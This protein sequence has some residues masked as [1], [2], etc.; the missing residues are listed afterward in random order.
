MA[1]VITQIANER[2]L[3]LTV[4]EGGNDE[5]GTMSKAFNTMISVIHKAFIVVNNSAVNVAESAE[6]VA[7]RAAGNR[8]RAANE[9]VRAK[10]SVGIIGDMGSTAAKVNQ[11]SEGQKVAAEVSA[12]TVRNLLKSVGEVSEAAKT[13]NKEA[14]ETM[15]R[16]SEMGATGAQV[17][18][19]AR[20][21]GAMVAKVSTAVTSITSAVESMNK[22][23]AQATL[24]G[25]ASL[26]AA[27]E[28]RRSVASTVEGMQAI[29]ESSEQISDIIGVITEIAEQTNL[30]A[31]NAAIEAA[32]AGAHGKGFAVV[33]DEVGKLAQRSSEAAKEITQLIKDSSARVEDG[34][35][36]TDESQKSL[37]K[38][39]EGGR[40]NMQAIDEIEKTATVLATGTAQVQNLMKELNKLA[41][42]IAGMAGEQGTRRVAAEKALTLLLEESERITALVAEANKGATD[43]GQE[44]TGIVVRT[45]EMSKM[46]GEQAI[47]SKKV[48]ELSTASADAAAQ[49]VE[50][51]GVVVSITKGLQDLSQ[52]LTT[53]VKQFKI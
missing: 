37:I 46:T 49:T 40:V 13:Q 24:H 3:T 19:T 48:T 43:I 44:M 36:L 42:N 38:I 10:E 1:S 51:A 20:E 15:A 33:A 29:A 17:V 8:E 45:D 25:K 21:Q 39:D 22:A 31:L 18:A 35:K 4:P 5:I 6:N 2:D 16:V 41:E 12:K 9:L 27:E 50:G 11:A 32:R 52:E 34:S 23:V 14:K 7:K 30:L 47:R 28:G 26:L 53:Q